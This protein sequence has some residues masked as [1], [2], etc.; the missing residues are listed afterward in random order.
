MV[1]SFCPSLKPASF[2]NAKCQW[3]GELLDVCRQGKT[4]RYRF[5]K[6]WLLNSSETIIKHLSLFRHSFSKYLD[7]SFLD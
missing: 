2:L 7:T 4:G 5:H 6:N 1:Y 3:C